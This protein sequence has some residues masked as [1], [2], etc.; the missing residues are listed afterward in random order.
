MY[1]APHP[2]SI[3]RS[4]VATEFFNAAMAIAP[5]GDWVAYQSNESGRAEVY[6]R[7]FPGPGRPILVSQGGGSSPV[8]SRDGRRLF[9]VSGENWMVASVVTEPTFRMESRTPFAP[10]DGFSVQT[11]IQRYDVSL[12]GE[13]LLAIRDLT[14]APTRYIVV[15]NVAA[16]LAARVRN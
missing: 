15:Q 11:L 8:W 3:P 12:D 13:R 6:V 10:T 5:N 16:D 4:F 14:N 1:A 9:F 7:P 2:D